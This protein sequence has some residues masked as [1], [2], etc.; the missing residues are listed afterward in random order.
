MRS[1]GARPRR[2]ITDPHFAFDP[3]NNVGHQRDRPGDG[4]ARGGHGNRVR[5]GDAGA[6]RVDP[7]TPGTRSLYLSIFDQGDHILDSTVMLDE[8]V[9]GGAGRVKAVATPARLEGTLPGVRPE[10]RHRH[11]VEQDVR[12]PPSDPDPQAQGRRLRDRDRVPEQ[13][14]RH[15]R[16]TS[17]VDLRGLPKGRITVQITVIT[18]SAIIWAPAAT[19]RAPPSA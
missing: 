16:L 6:A 15:E 18:T 3:A 13:D 19:A 1:R 14:A 5:R 7:V 12:Q 4:C 9:G 8:L 17:R 2:R 10:R 11:P